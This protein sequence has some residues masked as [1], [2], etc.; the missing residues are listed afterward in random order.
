M[1][2]FRHRHSVTG[3]GPRK[4]GQG[5]RPPADQG[6][7]LH[8][9][10]GNLGG[11]QIPLGHTKTG[12]II[13]YLLD[14]VVVT[15]STRPLLSEALGVANRRSRRFNGPAVPSRGRCH[16]GRGFARSFGPPAA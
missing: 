15:F 2:A 12:S 6:A 4:E 11:V 14:G 13:R 7:D 8:K 16:R 10:N 3:V 5:S 9:Q 1:P